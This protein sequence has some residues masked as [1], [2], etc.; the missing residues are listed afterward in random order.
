MHIRLFV[1]LFT[2]IVL[3][4]C[5]KENDSNLV[6]NMEMPET[7]PIVVTDHGFQY[8]QV[9]TTQYRDWTFSVENVSTRQVDS[10]G[11]SHSTTST[12]SGT[13]LQFGNFQPRQK[14]AFMI[15]T[16]TNVTTVYV[17]PFWK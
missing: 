5:D 15:R 4:G 3:M 9:S 13:T 7:D 1:L 14:T 12:A 6:C 8:T 10:V 17:R 2:L 16:S 11:V